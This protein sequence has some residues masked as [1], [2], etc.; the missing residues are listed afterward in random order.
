MPTQTFFNLPEDKRERIIVAALEEFAEHPYTRGSLS[1]IVRKAGIPKGSIYQ[2]FEDK[3]DL[4]GYLVELAAK[5]KLEYA[6]KAGVQA[7]GDFY[8]RLKAMFLVSQKFF[9]ERPLHARVGANA[10]AGGFADATV[11][12]GK[13]KANA[14]LAQMLLESQ[15]AGETR[16][17]IPVDMMVYYVNTLATG[18]GTYI[19]NSL[20]L[21][22]EDLGDEQARQRVMGQ[23]IEKLVGDLVELMKHGTAWREGGN[24]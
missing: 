20:G 7:T 5:E 21:T 18:F 19:L 15:K 22:L 24:L 4:Y 3:K 13:A 23:D 17:D 12:E 1:K 11:E 10:I 8:D 6:M 9:L 14:Y 2:Y 16:S